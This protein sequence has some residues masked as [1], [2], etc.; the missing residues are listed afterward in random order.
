LKIWYI[1]TYSLYKN[2]FWQDEAKNPNDFNPAASCGRDRERLARIHQEQSLGLGDRRFGIGGIARC[3][4]LSL[5]DDGD[6]LYNE[7]GLSLDV[8]CRYLRCNRES[9]LLIC[10]LLIS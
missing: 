8:A 4:S 1:T 6:R 7:R 10:W 2:R 3:A 9:C 5:A